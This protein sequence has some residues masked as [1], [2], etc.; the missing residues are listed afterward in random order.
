M[1]L[2]AV[3]DRESLLRQLRSA[4]QFTWL[5]LATRL[6]ALVTLAVLIRWQ[7]VV[8]APIVSLT[9]CLVIVGPFIMSVL[10]IWG[11]RKKR[12]EDL[13]ESTRFGDFDK[14]KLASL[15]RETVQILKLPSTKL[16]VYI[17]SDKSLNAGSVRLGLFFGLLNGIYLNRQVLHKLRGDEIQA[18]MGHELGH[19]YRFYLASDQYRILTLV[20]G[21]IVGIFTVQVARLDGFAGFIALSL[22]SYGFWYVSGLSTLRHGPAI[23]YLCDDLG[24]QVH[25]IESAISGLLKVGHDTESRYLLQLELLARCADNPLL[26]PQEVLD[27]IEKALPYGH[28]SETEMYESVRRELKQRSQQNRRVSLSGF[29][30]YLSESDRDEEDIKEELQN[31]A[32]QVNQIQRIEWE[33]ILDDPQEIRLNESQLKQLVQLIVNSPGQSLFRIPETAGDGVHPPIASR[34]LYLWKN[35]NSKAELRLNELV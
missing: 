22:I 6:I 3:P 32:K 15:Y 19:Y 18:I 16:P 33:S 21:A 31:Q 10:R 24:G 5:S 29:L 2:P 9:A 35:R 20:L 11:Q 27:S 34:I 13:K 23:E 30:K 8:F 14:H 4:N 12:L 17:T 28:A 7:E 1:D 26:S 25:G